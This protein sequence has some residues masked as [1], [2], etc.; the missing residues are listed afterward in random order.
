MQLIIEQSDHDALAAAEK[1]RSYCNDAG[2]CTHCIFNFDYCMLRQSDPENW[3]LPQV[4]DLLAK[5][6]P[7]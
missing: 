4:Y 2:P 3:D 6:G 7:S 5:G 1:L